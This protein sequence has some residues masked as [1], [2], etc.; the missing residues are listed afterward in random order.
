MRITF[1]LVL[2]AGLPLID[3]SA[4]VGDGSDLDRSVPPAHWKIP[5]APVRTPE[6]SLKLFDLP[7]GFRAEVVAA[8]PL[9]QDPIAMYFDERGRLWVLEW[10]SYNRLL[11]GVIPGLEKIDPPKSRVVILEDTDGD[12]RMDRRTI[13][14]DGFDWPRGLQVMGDGA[15]VLRLPEIV[16]GHDRDG[17]GEADQQEVLV[18]GLEV[19]ANP[20]G[21]QSNLFRGMDN[22]IYGSKFP[23][24]MRL[25]GGTWATQ[26]NLS[27]R[28]Q[29]GL[30]HDNY[31]RFV[32]ASN[33]DHLRGDLVPGHY[34]T[35]NPNYSATAGVD[36]RYPADQ[37]VWPHG[38]TP[39]VNRR[40][41]VRDENG[42]LQQFT[43]NT[44]PAVY[45]GNQFPSEFVGN[46]FLGD[47]A[48]RLIRRSVLT[49]KDGIITAEN[50][51]P[52]REFL[53]SHDERFRPV[54][55]AN[56]PDG[57]LYVTDMYRGIIEGHLF[58][59]SYL[60][61]QIIARGL[62]QS[63][64]GMGRIYRIVH[65]GRPRGAGPR[66]SRDQPAAWVEH[67][68]HPNGFWRDAAQRIIVESGDRRLIPSV[69]RIALEHADE[70][71]RLHGLWTLEGLGGVDTELLTRSLVDRS[72]QI[73]MA[74]LRL[75]EPFLA[76][77]GIGAKV[78]T[79]V[80]DERIEVRRQLLFTLGEGKGAAF[81]QAMARLLHR[82]AA[83]PIMLEAALSGLRDREYTLIERLLSDRSWSEEQ[84]GFARL[85]GALAH[86]VINSGRPDDLNRLLTQV[87]DGAERPLWSRVAI[88]DGLAAAKQRGLARLPAALA[89]V[90][91]SASDPV[92]KRAATLSRAWSTPVPLAAAPAS[93]PRR[94]AAGFDK[95][96]S[97]FAICSACHGA[98]GKGQPT[99]APPL[100][101]SLV[102]AGPAEDV[103]RSVINGRN[104]DRKN[105][106]YP[107]MPPLGGLGDEDIAAVVSFVRAQWGGQSQPVTA[108]D[109]KRVRDAP[110]VAPAAMPI[111][112]R[113]IP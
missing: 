107:D 104:Q 43:A 39:G 92:R 57:A 23:Q 50:A 70:L 100:A 45:R 69:R 81:E 112:R 7:A 54:F 74:A 94:S 66:L 2:T 93:R 30:S 89:A 86:A 87:A 21:A 48:G 31:G 60:R 80:E 83:Q 99:I 72:P 47:V 11:R 20:H 14:M 95:G 44:A 19:P 3:A 91:N 71:G 68:A 16:F 49:E 9:V 88:L 76:E 35:R 4:Q 5:T 58:I 108:A 96:Q 75:S 25:S 59:T 33:G 77:P 97:L 61:Q 82:D 111:L 12:G 38:A 98:E 109:V 73:R 1:W 110:A 85:F 26:P 56:G 102:V 37:T 78:L 79:L 15:L 90:E 53:F 42:T 67:L 65:A 103:I 55:T 51:Y 52:K 101:G 22:W 32:Y 105:Q 6:E 46:V 17:D 64:L 63:F 29:W 113:A 36:V 8:E 41:Q 106:A 28:G 18:G 34:Y 24:R 27:M 10:P 62:E 13:F 40:G 84:P